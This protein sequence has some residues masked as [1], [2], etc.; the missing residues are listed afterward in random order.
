MRAAFLFN[1][2]QI[3]QIAHSLPVALELKRRGVLRD[4]SLLVT[5]E[6]LGS[7]VSRL[8]ALAGEAMPIRTIHIQSRPAKIAARCLDPLFPAAKLAIYRDN[9]DL[10]RSFD[11]LVVSEKTSTL[12]KTRY[13]LDA[14]RLIH[15][16]HGAGD[17]AIGFESSSRAFDH[18]LAAGET[19]RRRLVE[20]AGVAADR[21]SVVGYP[22]FDLARLTEGRAPSFPEIRPTILYNPHVAPHLS[23]W[24]RHGRDVLRF[25]ARSKRYNLIF[26]PH[27]MLF[28]R[29]LTA[30]ISPPR[31]HIPGLIPPFVRRCPHIH[32]DLGSPA[33]SDMT[34]TRNADIYLGDAS[35]QVY[36]FLVEPRPCIFLNSHVVDHAHDANFA[37][38]QAGRVIHCAEELD[39]ALREAV[40][41]PQK[42]ASAQ[43]RL[44]AEHINLTEEPSSTRAAKAIERV[45]CGEPRG[46][47]AP[48]PATT[49]FKDAPPLSSHPHLD[50][51]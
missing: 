19:I 4:I 21:I 29:P 35:S 26:A 28:H 25:F 8:L 43:R 51:N 9:L 27:A 30:T 24:F 16:R 14:L 15:T 42:F 37:H 18:I 10:F 48:E 50:R 22:K 49:A 32:V 7:E 34:Y 45:A 36:E 1:H 41:Q 38:W 17:R 3:H 47:A 31:L 5:N 39:G 6:R 12:L 46:R 33:S 11:L 23:S 2:D 13:G 40:R 44:F 20:E